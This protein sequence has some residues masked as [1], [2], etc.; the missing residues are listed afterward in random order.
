MIEPRQIRAAR[1]LLDWTRDDLARASGISLNAIS[2]IEGEGRAARSVSLEKIRHALEAAGVVFTDNAGVKMRSDVL[3]VFE[4]IGG[5]ERFLDD[6]Y[7][8]LHTAS[9]PAV[10]VSGVEPEKFVAGR[11]QESIEHHAARMATIPN[12][13]FRVIASADDKNTRRELYVQYRIVESNQFYA[14]PVYGYAGKLAIII[15]EPKRKVIVISNADVYRAF[16][17]FFDLLWQRGRKQVVA[18]V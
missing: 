12:L 14:L 18:D 13:A 8:T 3:T 15:W 17:I 6:V 1:A 2:Q 9:D 10:F 7:M 5:F 16:S 11:T 4:D